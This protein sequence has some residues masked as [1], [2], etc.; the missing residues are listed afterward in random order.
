MAHEA[1]FRLQSFNIPKC[2]PGSL[3]SD[4][5]ESPI[6][7]IEEIGEFGGLSVAPAQ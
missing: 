7:P 2:N 4:M 5:K 6:H 3:A 1:S